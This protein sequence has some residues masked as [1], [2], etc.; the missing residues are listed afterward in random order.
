MVWHRKWIMRME[1][2]RKREVVGTIP[3]R[4]RLDSA[5]AEL[6]EAGFER[7]DLSLL[8]SHQSAE[9]LADDGSHWQSAITALAGEY[10]VLGPLAVS[11]GIILAGGPAAVAVAG[12]VGAAV[13]AMALAE[14]L[15]EML[16]EADAGNVTRAVEAGSI[17]LWVRASSPD[18]Q[19]AARRI[20]VKNG[21]THVHVTD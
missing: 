21:G 6:L 19:S 4:T 15:R 2:D 18:Q 16:S 20:L 3:D 9:A 7:A 17:I 1:N 10:N 8:S 5:V 14:V 13:G 12:I 11:G